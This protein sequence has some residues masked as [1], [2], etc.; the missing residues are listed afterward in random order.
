MAT[1]PCHVILLIITSN[2]IPPSPPIALTYYLV[3]D[4][5][6]FWYTKPHSSIV[7]NRFPILH[8]W[9]SPPAAILFIEKP[10]SC[11]LICLEALPPSSYCGFNIY[12]PTSHLLGCNLPWFNSVR[13]WITF[14]SLT[15]VSWWRIHQSIPQPGWWLAMWQ[16]SV[17]NP[18]RVLGLWNHHAGGES[19]ACWI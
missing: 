3:S 1:W 15:T 14:Y 18:H 4:D 13:I 12:S 2:D 11:Y 6:P 8:Y 7:G 5:S 10:T 9:K 16:K 17:F 19:T